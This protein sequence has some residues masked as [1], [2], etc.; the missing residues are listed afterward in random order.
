MSLSKEKKHRQKELESN[1]YTGK[2]NTELHSLNKEETDNMSTTELKEEL[3]S[4][5]L[6]G[7]PTE[8]IEAALRGRRE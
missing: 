8:K 1:G 4:R 6:E 7:D 5:G 3:F 2:T